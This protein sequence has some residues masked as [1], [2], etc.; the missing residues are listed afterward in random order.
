MLVNT[1]SE[2]LIRD[3]EKLKD[4]INLYTNEYDL[5]KLAEGISNTPGNLCLHIVGSLNHFIGANLGKTGYVRDREKEFSD[6]NISRAQIINKID[7]VIDQVKKTL[8]N[9]SDNQLTDE[10]P[11]EFLGTKRTVGFIIIQMVSHVNYHLGQ[12]NY[13]RRL[14]TI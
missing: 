9:I 1:F 8:S 5:W 11:V 12:I 4:E 7:E 6:K 10:F 3:L 2:I 14:I 13:H